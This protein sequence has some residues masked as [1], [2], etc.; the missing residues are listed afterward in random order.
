ML[1]RTHCSQTRTH[2]LPLD[3]QGQAI[4]EEQAVKLQDI[5]K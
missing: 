3:S 5:Q 2:C 4:Q 1:T